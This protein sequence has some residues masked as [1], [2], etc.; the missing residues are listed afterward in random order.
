[1]KMEAIGSRSLRMTHTTFHDGLDPH[2]L[3][4]SK[5]P[6]A[7]PELPAPPRRIFAFAVGA[8]SLGIALAIWIERPTGAQCYAILAARTTYLTAPNDG[9]LA[10]ILV[11]EGA[12]IRI[13]DELLRMQDDTLGRRILNKKGEIFALESELQHALAAAELELNWRIRTLESEMC[14]IQ[15]RSASFLKE[16]Y[17][18]ELQ[19]SMLSDVLTGREFV[20]ADGNDSLFNSIVIE[21]KKNSS[22]RMATV[23]E[24]ELAANAAEVS[25]AQVEICELRQ[26]QLHA[27]KTSLPEHIRRTQGVDVAEANVARAK[28]ELE[29]LELESL[30]L[31]VTSPAIGRVGVFQC[32]LGDHVKQG[33]PIVEL[34]DD[35]QLHLVAYV[36]SR[37]IPAFPV[38]SEVQLRFPGDEIRTGRVT[39]VAPQARPCS[40]QNAVGTDSTVLVQIEQT[41]QVWPTLPIGSQVRVRQLQN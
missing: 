10:E 31:N 25:A 32:R 8:L 5:S 27:L 23:L 14:D 16:K 7:C 17:N 15:L 34:L 11:A 6:E 38:E 3:S 18:F 21:N 37:D 30:E 13:G 24:M 26:K 9:K 28:S 4:M 1:M 19:R 40:I 22:Q 35:S 41:G 12:R 36:P 39:V 20:M 2:F 29:Q 33:T